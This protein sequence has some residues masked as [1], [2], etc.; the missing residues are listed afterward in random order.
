MKKTKLFILLCLPVFALVFTGQM[1]GTSETAQQVEKATFSDAEISFDYPAGWSKDTSSTDTVVIL[2]AANDQDNLN[3]ISVDMTGQEMSLDE[4]S[5][6]SMEGVEQNIPGYVYVKDGDTT[7]AGY[8][9]HELIFTATKDGQ[10]LKFWQVWTIAGNTAYAV[11]FTASEENFANQ[12]PK[13]QAL[14]DS[15]KIK[16]QK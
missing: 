3:V 15:F 8:P 1:C 14:L 11:T 12:K 9:A 4:F 7:L 5:E 2:T 10:T 13:I 16:A 6:L